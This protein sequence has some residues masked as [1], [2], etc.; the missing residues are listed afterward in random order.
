M[1]LRRRTWVEAV[2]AGAVAVALPA[3]AA[4]ADLLAERGRQIALQ[5]C[6]R[7]HVVDPARPF[8]GISSTPSFQLLV[9]AF[10][11]W[12]ERFETF[13]TRRPHP[14]VV[15]FAGVAPLSEGPPIVQTV[16]LQLADIEAIVA[17]AES[18]KQAADAAR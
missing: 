17:F 7:C 14:A 1:A 8:T 11:D 18:L 2:L 15:R 4:E 16:D 10:D 5:H 12:R 13:H 3:L 6:V 9:T